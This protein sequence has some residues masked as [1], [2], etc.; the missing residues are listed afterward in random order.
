MVLGLYAADGNS[1]GLG[2]PSGQSRAAPELKQD[3]ALHMLG[4][5]QDLLLE[6]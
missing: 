2:A 4:A 5:L 1:G 3:T 6:G